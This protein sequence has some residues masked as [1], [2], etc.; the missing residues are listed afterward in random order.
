MLRDTR[1]GDR[2]NTTLLGSVNSM[3]ALLALFFSS[4]T[5][6]DSETPPNDSTEF[7]EVLDN[8]FVRF[9]SHK[10]LTNQ[11]VDHIANHGFIIGDDSVAIIDP[12]GSRQQAL[13]TIETVAKQTHLPISHVI[14]THVHPDHSLGLE[15]YIKMVQQMPPEILGHSALTRD[16]QHNLP[17][18]AESFSKDANLSALEQTLQEEFITAVDTLHT[19]DLGNH[20]L[21]LQSFKPAHSRTDLVVLDHKHNTLWAGD[22]LFVDRLPA[23]DGSLKGWLTAIKTIDEQLMPTLVIPGHGN[24]GDWRALSAVQGK[25]LSHLLSQTQQAIRDGISLNQYVSRSLLSDTLQ[26]SFGL[27]QTQHA[28]N[29]SKAFTELEWE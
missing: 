25:Y 23:L 26:K 21:T 11:T 12:G 28:T 2:R 20:K 15:A 9:G 10:L 7:T 22:L 17:Y 19:I 14:V 16:L 27:L 24:M 6:A 29:L 8:V 1:S 4:S 5:L 3:I 13:L 18:F